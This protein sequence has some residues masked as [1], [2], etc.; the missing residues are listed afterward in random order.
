MYKKA[1]FIFLASVWARFVIYPED[2]VFQRT[3]DLI[4]KP[5]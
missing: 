2:F 5:F 3:F 4:K 1:V